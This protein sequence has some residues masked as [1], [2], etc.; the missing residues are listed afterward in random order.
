MIYVQRYELKKRNS[1]F[2]YSFYTEVYFIH[3]AISLFMNLVDDFLLFCYVF[4]F[5]LIFSGNN[6]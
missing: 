4:R 5:S 2:V 6:T 1:V 3:N